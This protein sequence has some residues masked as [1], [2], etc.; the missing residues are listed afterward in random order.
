MIL[1]IIKV[2][3]II[4]VILAAVYGLALLV[5]HIQWRR[6]VKRHREERRIAYEKFRN[7]DEYDDYLKRM[8]WAREMVKK[9]EAYRQAKL[10]EEGR[11]DEIANPKVYEDLE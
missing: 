1:N 6:S 11:E 5:W 8:E 2:L 4:V 7:S 3:L 10:I 9:A